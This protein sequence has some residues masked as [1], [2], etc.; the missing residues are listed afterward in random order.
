MNNRILIERAENV[1]RLLSEHKMTLSVAE[2]CTGGLLSKVITDISGASAVYSGGVCVYCNKSKIN[3][4][5]V[6]ADTINSFGAVSEQ[7][8]SQMSQGVCSLFGSDVGIGIT[9]I[10]GPASDGTDKPVGLIYISITV[11]RDTEVTQ[12]RNI[13]IRDIRNSNRYEAA[14]RALLLLEH[15]LK[16][17]K[18]KS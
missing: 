16:S 4:L 18:G 17:L 10:A 7:T 12:L 8:A 9:G 2:S 11:G 6:S 13:F 3:L 5:D 15:K 14:Y 1:I